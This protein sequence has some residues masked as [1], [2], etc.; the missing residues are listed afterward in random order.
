MA[1]ALAS[2]ALVVAVAGLNLS[3]YRT[4]TGIYWIRDSRSIDLH[5]IDQQIYEAIRDLGFVR[6]ERGYIEKSAQVLPATRLRLEG[7]ESMV[8]V[9]VSDDPLAITVRDLSNR[10]ETEFTREVKRRIELCLREKYGLKDLK[11]ERQPEFVPN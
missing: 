11:F 7:D 4:Y 8:T 2:L 1:K 5:Q 6:I 10:R 3:C 9:A